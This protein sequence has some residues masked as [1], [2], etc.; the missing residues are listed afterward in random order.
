MK[1]PTTL[2]NLRLATTLLILVE[3]IAAF[4][5][6]AHAVEPPPVTILQRNGPLADGF[7]FISPQGDAQADPAHP[8][9]MGPEI[10]DD[11]GRPVWFPPVT[12]D[13][14]RA[15]D[16]RVQSYQGQPVLTW[17]QGGPAALPAS[18]GDGGYILDQSYRIIATVRAGNGLRAE[19]HEFRL[20]PQNTA[21]L[22]IYNYVTADLS[23][24]GGA[25]SAKV[26]E[27]VVQEVDV[28]TG[29]VLLEWHS[30]ADVP[31]TESYRALPSAAE[32]NAAYDYFHL[33]SVSPSS[34]AEKV[35]MMIGSG[36][37]FS[38][39]GFRDYIGEDSRCGR[40]FQSQ[41]REQL[42]QRF[43]GTRHHA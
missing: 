23:A 2:H 39:G 36:L 20:T 33:N 19:S 12:G 25:A 1:T 42:G 22:S 21:L 29:R 14:I 16:F 31:V 32:P 28:A 9:G 43:V 10:V 5:Q 40:Q 38:R 35:R 6:R 41:V 34:S 13:Q 4:P 8:I 18:E 11:H 24:I 17:M 3:L 30:L 27:G 37:R 7:I 26:I 15:T